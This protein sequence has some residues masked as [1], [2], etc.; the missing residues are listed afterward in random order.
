MYAFENFIN[1]FAL[2]FLVIDPIGTLAVF[3][4]VMPNIKKNKEKVALEAVSYAFLILV[5]FLLLGSFILAHLN[6]DLYSLKIAGGIILLI[7]SLEMMFDK[8]LERKKKII[9]SDDIYNPI[10]PLAIPLLAGPASITS[11]IV[12]TSDSLSYSHYINN[13]LAILAV[14]IITLFLF[15]ITLRFERFLKKQILQVTSRIIGILLAALSL[16][17]ILDGI[18]Q[19]I[20]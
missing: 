5:F 15:L 14:L 9:K 4:S 11:V 19:F 12:T 2:Y 13:V 8:R 10:F 16:Q 3:L 7:I 17:Y 1:F 18:S 6:I 20:G